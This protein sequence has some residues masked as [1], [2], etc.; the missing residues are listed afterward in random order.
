MSRDRVTKD[1]AR[2]AARRLDAPAETPAFESWKAA[3]PTHADAFESIWNTSQDPA[4]TEALALRAQNRTAPRRDRRPVLAPRLI[5]GLALAACAVIGLAVWPDL[6]VM[7]VKPIVLETPP[8]QHRDVALADGTKVTLD[9]ATRLDVQLGDH[10]RRVRLVRGEAFFDVAHD[11]ARPFTVNSTEGSVRVLGTAFDLERGDGRL[12][13]AVH[14]GK[15]R[16]SP[17]GLIH[18]SADLTVG[19]RATVGEGALSRT[20]R[21]DPTVEDWRSGWLE[22]EGLPLDRLVQRLNRDSATPIVITDP[23]LAHR[24]VAGRFRLDEPATLIE[25]LALMQGFK[26]RRAGERLEL[27]R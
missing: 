7:T 19:Q 3:D 14:R 12:D 20:M 2:W 5:A 21:F 13:L 11:A 10:R 9:G 22:T 23:A 18:R 4:L 6:Q 26:V 16:F 15:V 25:N 27:S 17:K 8:G 24:L 1:A